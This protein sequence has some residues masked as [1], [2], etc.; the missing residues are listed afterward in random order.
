MNRSPEMGLGWAV[1][2]S[3]IPRL[4]CPGPMSAIIPHLSVQ[5]GVMLSPKCS[6][7]AAGAAWHRVKFPGIVAKHLFSQVLGKI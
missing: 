5:E 6:V 4:L 1:M 2:G 3:E 7:R